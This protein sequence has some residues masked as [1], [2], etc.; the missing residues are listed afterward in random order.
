MV[1][2]EDAKS[3]T[4]TLSDGTNRK[5]KH[6]KK[7]AEKKEKIKEKEKEGQAVK[8]ILPNPPKE[9]KPDDN[10][11]QEKIKDEKH[12]DKSDKKLPA[13]VE[14]E[15]IATEDKRHKRKDEH[16][17]QQK[18]DASE[19]TEASSVNNA[20]MYGN[21]L[22]HVKETQDEAT[23]NDGGVVKADEFVTSDGPDSLTVMSSKKKKKKTRKNSRGGETPRKRRVGANRRRHKR[24]ARRQRDGKTHK[25]N[26]RKQRNGGHSNRGSVSSRRG[27]KVIRIACRGRRNHDLIFAIVFFSSHYFYHEGRRS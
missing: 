1:E 26:N 10:A 20:E 27:I 6:Q 25:P 16:S 2:F 7:I 21:T 22:D 23:N 24:A 8:E 3:K 17:V 18:E 5:E 15:E 19:E 13:A 12:N 11:V 9:N 14:V 4:N